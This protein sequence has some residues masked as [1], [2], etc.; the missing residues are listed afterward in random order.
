V[1]T[2]RVHPGESNS[3]Y[4]LKGFIDHLL[5]ETREARL[6]RKNYI[7]KII[8]MLNVDG[9]IYGN[10]RCSLIGADLNRRWQA[11]SR[12]LHP[13]IYHAKKVV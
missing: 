10:Y 5:S 12:V 6:I 13:T 2:A 3:S 8:P 11:P 4:V 9:V 7:I 1:I